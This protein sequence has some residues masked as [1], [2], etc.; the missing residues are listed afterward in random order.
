MVNSIL[1]AWTCM[2]VSLKRRFC[3]FKK[4]ISRIPLVLIWVIR[5][6]IEWCSQVFLWWAQFGCGSWTLMVTIR[7]TKKFKLVLIVNFTQFIFLLVGHF[8]HKCIGIAFIRTSYPAFKSIIL[9]YIIEICFWKFVLV[10]CFGI[11]VK[12]VNKILGIRNVQILIACISV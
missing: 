7:N 12:S 1:C 8:Y 5:Y 6:V 2:M 11:I 3:T 4:Y 10:N 9:F